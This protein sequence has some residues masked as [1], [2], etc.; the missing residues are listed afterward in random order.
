MDRPARTFVLP[1]P[2]VPDGRTIRHS[3]KDHDGDSGT[4]I[5]IPVTNP[6]ERVNGEIKRR[7]NVVGIFP[8]E[9]AIT[10]PRRRRAAR[11]ERR[12]DRRKEVHD[13]GIDRSPERQ[14]YDQA[15]RRGSLN[16]PAL[17]T[18][19]RVKREPLTPLLGTRSGAA[20]TLVPGRR[21]S[22]AVSVPCAQNCPPTELAHVLYVARA[23]RRQ[24]VGQAIVLARLWRSVHG[25]TQTATHSFRHLL[26]TL[27]YEVS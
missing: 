13:A 2:L 11:A 15:V 24:D 6:L 22:S 17:P 20:R 5:F 21:S 19:C 1:V 4:D 16:N 25:A 18:G 27:C 12:M 23:R 3:P 7:T 9:D 14:S 8:N 10:R 26:A